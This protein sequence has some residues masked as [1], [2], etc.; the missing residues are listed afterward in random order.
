[1]KLL[2]GFLDRIGSRAF[3]VLSC[4]VLFIIYPEYPA[5]C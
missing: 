4:N 1:M 5:G 2:E 3:D